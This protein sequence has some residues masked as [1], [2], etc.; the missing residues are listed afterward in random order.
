MNYSQSDSD[1]WNRWPEHLSAMADAA[2]SA[3]VEGTSFVLGDS[4][5]ES[6]PAVAIMRMPPNY[7]LSRHAHRAERLEVVVQGTLDVGDRVLR[8][9]DVMT[10]GYE[11]AYGEHVAGPEGCTTVEVFSQ[12]VGMHQTIFATPDGMRFLDLADPQAPMVQNELGVGAG[13][14]SSMEGRGD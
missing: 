1:Y 2:S 4:S 13:G 7:V 9:G 6:A 14:T 10:A 12:L 11:E 8:P 5:D 3:G